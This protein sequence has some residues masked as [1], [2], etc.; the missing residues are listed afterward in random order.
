MQPTGSTIIIIARKKGSETMNKDKQFTIDEQQD[1]NK[2][3]H[4]ILL[5]QKRQNCPEKGI[6]DNALKKENGF[7]KSLEL[8]RMD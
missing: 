7:W 4:K 2:V 6:M 8:E 1:L 3:L 5:E